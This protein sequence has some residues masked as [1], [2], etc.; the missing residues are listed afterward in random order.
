MPASWGD[1]ILVLFGSADGLKKQIRGHQQWEIDMAVD[2]VSLG[3][4]RAGQLSLRGW[5]AAV[6]LGCSA[7]AV[8][9]DCQNSVFLFNETLEK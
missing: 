2:T 5:R 3:T 4:L 9:P 8:L 6:L 7:S 1:L